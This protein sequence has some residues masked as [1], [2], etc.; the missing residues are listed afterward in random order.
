[1]AGG[2]SWEAEAQLELKL[3]K[4]VNNTK[5]SGCYYFNNKRK[6]K[7]DVG[8]LFDKVGDLLKNSMEKAMVLSAFFVSVFTS[9]VCSQA[10]WV[11]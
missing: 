4:D 2:W 10:S 11:P 7:E 3:A 5:E 6:M 1:M 9:K 8:T